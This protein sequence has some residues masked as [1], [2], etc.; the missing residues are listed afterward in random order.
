MRETK[1]VLPNTINEIGSSEDFLCGL[2]KRK[3][4]GVG[5]RVGSG[6]S[7]RKGEGKVERRR[8]GENKRKKC[9]GMGGGGRNEGRRKGKR[10]EGKKKR[11][12]EEGKEGEVWTTQEL[13]AWRGGGGGL[14]T[15]IL[16]GDT[17]AAR[18]CVGQTL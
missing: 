16:Q 18:C 2:M 12:G 9:N 7:G 4:G 8:V 10:R 17:L 15:L 11:E 13:H 14:Q 6:G 3:T 5:V 1:T